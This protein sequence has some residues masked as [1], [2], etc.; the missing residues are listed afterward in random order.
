[1]TDMR[2]ANLGS[3]DL[4]LL[5]VLATVLEERSATR[6]AKRLHVTQSAVS[7]ALRRL[8]ELFGDQLVV[9]RPHG[10]EPTPR[11][12]AL[13]PRL[14][15]WAD[16]TRGLLGDPPAFDPQRSTRTF[17]IACSDA[18]ATALLQPILRLMRERCPA[19]RLRLLTL[20]RA[21][22]EDGLA[23]GQVDL[24]VGMPPVLPEGHD[25]ELVYRDPMESI[26]RTG[27]PAVRSR[28]TLDAF[29]R[30][31]HVDV[32]LFD[33]VNDAID[34]AL[35]K[36]GRVRVVQVALPHFSSV[37]LAV[38]ETDC[39]ATLSSRLARAAA[40]RLPLRVLKPPVALEPV[41]VRQVWHR[42]FSTDDAVL[43]LR[44]LVRDAAR[45]RAHAS[46]R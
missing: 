35:A 5:H 24:L 37:P 46:L 15:E 28:L 45:S 30:L 40:A 38:A 32:A 2:S 26:V 22:P 19:A 1:M 12:L 10:L 17:R 36:H 34:K 18:V 43:F 4:N 25:A 8:R 11:A 39:V 13:L 21:L 33:D 9:R 29:T 41:E 27:H 23:R 31:P 7:N 6:A 20:D 14:R 3:V 16:D 42:R 44:E